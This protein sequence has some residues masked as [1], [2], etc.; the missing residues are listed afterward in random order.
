MKKTI[1]L[2]SILILL[3]CQSGAFAIDPS[4]YGEWLDYASLIYYPDAEEKI[5]TIADSFANSGYTNDGYIIH[6]DST[7]DIRS[8][9]EI[10][11]TC[12]WAETTDA[13]LFEE[14]GYGQTPD[15][16]NY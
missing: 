1:L 16:T 14:G 7:V 5:L 3:L 2:I 6:E 12:F 15:H 8:G 10:I 9:G 4:F 13:L 11:G